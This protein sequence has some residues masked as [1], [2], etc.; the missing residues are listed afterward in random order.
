MESGK[1]EVGRGASKEGCVMLF[2]LGTAYVF[3]TVLL[4]FLKEEMEIIDSASEI[5][6]GCLV[7]DIGR[8]D[9]GVIHNTICLM[10]LLTYSIKDGRV[11]DMV[12]ECIGN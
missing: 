9:V 10:V 5:R 3:G 1:W 2:F 7:Y 11:L 8:G 12:M 4:L 6:S